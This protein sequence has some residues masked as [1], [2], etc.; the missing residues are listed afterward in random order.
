MS[1]VRRDPPA[2]VADLLLRGGRVIDPAN[3]HD[4]IADLAIR[5]GR[6]VAVGAGAQEHTPK[7][8]IDVRGA[9]VTPGFDM[10]VHVYEWVTNFGVPADS[11]GVQPGATTI[12]D[13]GSSGARTFGGFK[14]LFRCCQHVALGT[15]GWVRRVRA[16]PA[17]GQRPF[18]PGVGVASNRRT[19]RPSCRS[20]SSA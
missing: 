6:V 7:R 4:G 8:Q 16:L 9:I 3:G 11:A 5:N 18:S 2:P 17:P 14:A 13:Q 1:A 19:G 15:S 12:V 20:S 10:R